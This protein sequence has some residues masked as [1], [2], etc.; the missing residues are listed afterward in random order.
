MTISNP[1]LSVAARSL[2]VL[3]TAMASC[4]AA[5]ASSDVAKVEEDWELVL[6]EPSDGKNSPQ[7]ETVMSP[8]ANANSIYGRLTWNYRELPDFQA[9]GLQ[10]QAWNGSNIVL[11]KSF[12][13]NQLSTVGETIT[14]TQRLESSSSQL[15]WRVV[16][17]SSTTWGPFGGYQME[18]A[19][20]TNIT[21]LNAYSP[22]VSISNSGITYGAN[23]VIRLRIKE[24]RK[25]RSDGTLIS[26]DTTS[27]DVFK[28]ASD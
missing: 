11:K 18:I 2:L 21:H 7:L 17:G 10:M 25:Y 28:R 16:N 15:S 24:I 3:V 20:Y 5:Q 23:R 9:G 4:A 26:K 12:N 27:K 14:W 8:F 19:G 1:F 13:G 6:D 22:N